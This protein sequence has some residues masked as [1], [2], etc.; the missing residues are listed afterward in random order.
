[1]DDLVALIRPLEQ[2][3]NIA[4][5]AHDSSWGPSVQ[6]DDL[7]VGTIGWDDVDVSVHSHNRRCQLMLIISP[8]MKAHWT[9]VAEGTPCHKI[10]TEI[11]E[12]ADISLKHV[13]LR[14]FTT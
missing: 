11:R 7:Y 9:A 6:K 12:I 8:G 4:K 3:I 13:A 14:K 2:E 5:G 10:I 1:M